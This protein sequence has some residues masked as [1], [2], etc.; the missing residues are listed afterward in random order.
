MLHATRPHRGAQRASVARR[1]GPI[2]PVSPAR[3]GDKKRPPARYG[4]RE[5]TSMLEIGLFHNGA[6]SLPIVTG[7]DD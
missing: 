6:S 5:E 2:V 1:V 3:A 7:K 4:T